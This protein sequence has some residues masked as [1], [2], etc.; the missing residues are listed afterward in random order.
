MATLEPM[1]SDEATSRVRIHRGLILSLIGI[2]IALYLPTVGYDFVNW[3]DP[4]YVINN[5]LIKSWHPANLFQIFT[6]VAIKNFAP[7][8]LLSYLIE[9]TLWG[10]WPGGYHL[11]NVLL[12]AVNT[13]LVFV[14]IGRLTNNRFIGWT[15]AALFAVHPVHIETVAWVA[16]RKGLLSGSFI[17]AAMVYRLKPKP[18]ERDEGF[19]LLFLVLALVSKAIAVVVPVI[20]LTYDLAVRRD[21]PA[22][23]IARQLIPAFFCLCLLSITMSAQST[24]FGGLRSHMELSKAHILAVDSIILWKYIGLLVWPSDLCILYDPPTSGIAGWVVLAVTGWLVVTGVVYRCRKNRPLVVLAA[25]TF[26]A[27]LLPVLNL[28]PITTLMNDRYLYLPSIPFFALTAAGVYRLSLMW[29]R[30]G[31]RLLSPVLSRGF[32]IAV[33]LCL[34]MTLAWRTREHLSVWK[35]DFALWEHANQHVPHL[36]VVQIQRAS[37]LERKGDTDQAVA[38]LKSALLNS[39]P[40]AADRKRIFKKLAD[41]QR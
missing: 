32:C 3:D 21:R 5:P 35:N 27:F 6:E 22:E 19:F 8:T 37:A 2:V 11:T 26:I 17:L 16:S 10:L 30:S 28:F 36:T 20:V 7:L 18:T 15:T 34:V 4:W 9:H 29:K 25:V 38:V 31:E 1:T 40:D 13:A 23:A 24:M 41:W 14:L 39:N 12:H 33:A